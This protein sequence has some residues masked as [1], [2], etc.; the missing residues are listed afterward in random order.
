[1]VLNNAQLEILKLF[2]ADLT[3]NDLEVLRE[4]LIE[5]RYRRL[6]T[7]FDALNPSKEQLYEWASGHDRTAYKAYHAKQ[8]TK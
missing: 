7:S 4:W 2:A 5:F 1:M 3:D 6:Q 8:A